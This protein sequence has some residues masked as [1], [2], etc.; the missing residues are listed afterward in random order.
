MVEADLRM[1]AGSR[2]GGKKP[3]ELC[4]GAGKRLPQA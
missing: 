3:P 2:P 4:S 1:G